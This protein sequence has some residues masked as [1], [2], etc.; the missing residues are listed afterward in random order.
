MHARKAPRGSWGVS[1]CFASIVRLPHG[2]ASPVRL[3]FFPIATAAVEVSP[4]H[5]RLSVHPPHRPPSSRNRG[6]VGVPRRR[7]RTP[8]TRGY[9]YFKYGSACSKSESPP[10]TGTWC[11]L[12]P[13]KQPAMVEVS[14]GCSSPFSP[15]PPPSSS[16]RKLL[17]GRRERTGDSKGTLKHDV[18]HAKSTGTSCPLPLRVC[19]ARRSGREGL[20]YRE[21]T[22]QNRKPRPEATPRE[23]DRTSQL[24]PPPQC[25]CS[26]GRQF[27]EGQLVRG[28]PSFCRAE[29]VAGGA[30][31]PGA[32]CVRCQREME[33]FCPGFFFLCVGATASRYNVAH[34]C[35]G[36]K[37]PFSRLCFL[38]CQRYSVLPWFLPF[39]VSLL[40]FFFFAK[41]YSENRGKGKECETLIYNSKQCGEVFPKQSAASI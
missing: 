7:R 4:P 3:L 33:S 11:A 41:V 30:G 26:P 27:H 23:D 20:L 35:A 6:M 19:E 38:A 25:S 15:P 22:A 28:V 37:R 21:N 34:S 13:K 2:L 39:I 1:R 17:V 12:A 32:I 14:G 8:N 31:R 24:G 18:T 9:F 5:P 29:L 10:R 40:F 16:P 36:T